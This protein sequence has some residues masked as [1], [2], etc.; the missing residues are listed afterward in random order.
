MSIFLKDIPP[1]S[2]KAAERFIKMVEDNVRSR[3]LIDFCREYSNSMK[4]LEKRKR[5]K[6]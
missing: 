6:K 3:G 2:G 1:L 4:I 5:L